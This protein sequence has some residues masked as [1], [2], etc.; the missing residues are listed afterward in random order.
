MSDHGAVGPHD[1]SPRCP[2]CELVDRVVRRADGYACTNC[3]TTFQ[4][5]RPEWVAMT[6]ARKQW[7]D[8]YAAPRT[9]ER[10]E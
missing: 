4:G 2:R 5:T 6:A 8:V 9:K 10:T 3:W 1:A 7:R